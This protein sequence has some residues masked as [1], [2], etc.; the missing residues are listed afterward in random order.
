MI[1]CLT[2]GVSS[3]FRNART[4][5]SCVL[6]ILF[7]T[8]VATVTA[9]DEDVEE[10]VFPVY[11]DANLL[12]D[13]EAASNVFWVDGD[14]S[15]GEV[16]LQF[17]DGRLATL[18][19]CGGLGGGEAHFQARL[20]LHTPNVKDTE[21]ED[22]V[23]VYHRGW[24]VGSLTRASR[25][26][27]LTVDLDPCLLVLEPEINLMLKARGD[28]GTGISPKLSGKGA[29]LEIVVFHPRQ[30]PMEAEVEGGR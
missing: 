14:D 13:R 3:G 1:R 20:K 22:G 24:K 26:G 18:P 17:R 27:W 30:D 15:E 2:N 29:R 6:A 5:A 28:D 7:L 25:N 21:S 10:L 23:D 9:A 16:I 4:I 8:G 19:P 11:K 12:L